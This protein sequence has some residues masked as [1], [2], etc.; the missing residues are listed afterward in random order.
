MDNSKNAHETE[1]VK[2]REIIKRLQFE[3]EELS[4]NLFRVNEKLV[5]S[6][7]LK[8]HF[9]SNVTNEI[10][11]PFTSILALASNIRQLKDNEM[12][13]AQRM[14]GLIYEEAFHLDFQLKNIFAAALIEAGMDGLNLNRINIQEITDQILQ[15]FK[16]QLLK[17]SIRISVQYSNLSSPEELLVFISD[18]PKFDLILKNIISN[19]IKFSPDHSV[20]ELKYIQEDG[21]LKI[22]VSDTGKG[23]SDEDIKVI[24]DRFKQLDEKINSINTGHGLGLSVVQAYTVMLGGEVCI[25][26]NTDGGVRVIV[27]LPELQLT[28][29]LDGLDG[30]LLDS[31]TSF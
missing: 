30:F 19:A 6:E 5:D 21:L 23:I 22:E 7:K 11:N 8:G 16:S 20:I 2:S 14:A 4:L 27:S 26:G 10:I 13:K 17:R 9:I 12:N 1:L 3:N 24:F 25:T 15:Y 18:L 31:D 29:E 28:G